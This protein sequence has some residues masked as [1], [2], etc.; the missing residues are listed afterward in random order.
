MTPSRDFERNP[1]AEPVA[2]MPSLLARFSVLRLKRERVVRGLAVAPGLWFSFTS[3]RVKEIA[4]GLSSTLMAINWLRNLPL[5]P[6]DQKDSLA[7]RRKRSKGTQRKVVPYFQ[8]FLCGS[9]RTSATS[10]LKQP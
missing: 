1:S 5:E 9:L 6:K 8:F 2:A 7:Q 4:G 10:A 3:S